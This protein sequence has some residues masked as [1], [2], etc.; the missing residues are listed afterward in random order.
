MP[1]RKLT[2][3]S[4]EATP[5]W[6]HG[7][8][9]QTDC[10]RESME[11]PSRRHLSRPIAS[12]SFIPSRKHN[13]IPS[14]VPPLFSML[15]IDHEYTVIRARTSVFMHTHVGRGSDGRAGGCTDS[16]DDFCFPGEGGSGDDYGAG[17]YL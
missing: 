17:G 4:A 2:G 15:L 12:F 11:Q 6:H 10:N 8:D 5:R 14:F 7:G 13:R 16:N 1:C 9:Q 3:S